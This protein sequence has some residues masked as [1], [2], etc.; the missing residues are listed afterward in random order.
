MRTDSVKFGGRTVLEDPV[1]GE[2]LILVVECAVT[3]LTTRYD[4]TGES[5]EV[6][7]LTV[8]QAAR[9]SEA[10]ISGAVDLLH[11][12]ADRRDGTTRLPLEKP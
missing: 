11:A 10:M 4:D 3:A 2:R 7:T 9:P 8:E 5:R 12:A 6:Y 1:P